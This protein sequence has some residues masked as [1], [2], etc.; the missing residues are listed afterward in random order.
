MIT[1]S[2]LLHYTVQINARLI[3][4]SNQSVL[5]L[6]QADGKCQQRFQLITENAE[7]SSNYRV[8]HL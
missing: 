4:S 5:H 1:R 7:V 3:K 2:S 8:H 6:Q